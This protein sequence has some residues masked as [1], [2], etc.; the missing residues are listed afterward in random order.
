[1]ATDNSLTARLQR[2]LEA[3]SAFALL[4]LMLVVLVD[5]VGRNF[6]NKPLPWGTELLEIVL[7]LMIFLLYP[8]LGL[9]SGHITVDLIQVPPWV[10][11]V[12]RVL[13]GVI[14]ATVFGIIAWCM[15][16]QALRASGYGEATALLHIP[17]SLVIGGMSA[18]A[19]VTSFAFVVSALRLARPMPH[20]PTKEAI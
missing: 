11:R 7:A 1:M 16:R 13:G 5:V 6:F 9:R 3:G 4:V 19:I 8:V 10:Q 17:L 2:V 15:G 20:D 18:M 12:Q 14:G